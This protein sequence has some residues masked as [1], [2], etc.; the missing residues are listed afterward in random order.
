MHAVTFIPCIIVAIVLASCGGQ[1]T[2]SPSTVPDDSTNPPLPGAPDAGAD[3]SLPW[4]P[5]ASADAEPADAISPPK[6]DAP[7]PPW[8]PPKD[9][10]PT[11][12]KDY[13]AVDGG[14]D[15]DG[16]TPAPNTWENRT[17]CNGV[18]CPGWCL[19]F[20]GATSPVCMCA[21]IDGGC[22]EGWMCCGSCTLPQYCEYHPGPY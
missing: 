18:A 10:K 14:H 15:C 7:A 6:K 1:T 4:Q 20:N 11:P 19:L 3:V 17:C 5:D 13:V 21:G 8:K 22:P 12:P 9:A 2:T 16:G